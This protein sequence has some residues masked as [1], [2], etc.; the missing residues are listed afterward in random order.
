MARFTNTEKMKKGYDKEGRE[1]AFGKPVHDT[2]FDEW[3]I[4][5]YVDNYVDEEKQIFGESKEDVL[6]TMEAELSNLSDSKEAEESVEELEAQIRSSLAELEALVE[7]YIAK[8]AEYKANEVKKDEPNLTES[9]KAVLKNIV[10]KCSAFNFD[11]IDWTKTFEENQEHW[12]GNTFLSFTD[13]RE[14]ATKEMSS[15]SY[16]GII[17]SLN[18][19][20]YISSWKDDELND[21]H[22]LQI[23]KSNFEK[24]LGVL[25]RLD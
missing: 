10:K 1:I 12:E 25:D 11:K 15:K 14:Y 20:G 22:W 24:I 4:K 9:E 6:S 7:S 8:V 23:G 13:N 16:S 5:V 17:A 3:S 18:K 2:Y 19:K 21:V